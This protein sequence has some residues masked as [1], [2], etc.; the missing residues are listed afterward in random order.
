MSVSCDKLHDFV[1]GELTEEQAD[2]FRLH[3]G[4]CET[5]PARL[6][7][8]LQMVALEDAAAS[9]ADGVTDDAPTPAHEIQDVAEPVDELAARRNRRRLVFASGAVL[10]AAAAV[11][12]ILRSGSS[13]TDEGGDAIALETGPNRSL[14]LRISESDEHK[15]Y[16]VMRSG[17]RP[18][19]DISLAVLNELSE[20]GNNKRLANAYLLM[21]EPDK[22][23]KLLA[24]LE[25]TADVLA[26]R[27][28]AA[29]LL[30]DN[31]TALRYFA[32]SLAK[33][34]NNSRVLWN[35]AIVH[36]DLNLPLSAA[37]LFRR[38]A[39]LGEPG[40]AEEAAKQAA[41]LQGFREAAEQYK[42][43]YQDGNGA[44]AR[45]ELLAL[46]IVKRYPGLGRL[47]FYDAVASAGT[48][49]R[50][51]ELRPH[52]A[53]LDDSYGGASVEQFLGTVTKGIGANRVDLAAVF[54]LSLDSGV[55]D[56]KLRAAYRSAKQDRDLVLSLLVKLRKLDAQD[57]KTLLAKT[58]NYGRWWQLLA[59]TKVAQELLDEGRPREAQAM[60]E[61]EMAGCRTNPLAYRCARV[62]SLLV[63]L[64]GVMYRTEQARSAAKEALE[65][66]AQVEDVYGASRTRK[67]LAQV[68]MASDELSESSLAL[69]RAYLREELLVNPHPCQASW[70]HRIYSHLDMR[71]RNVDS[72][73]QFDELSE[74]GRVECEAPL[75]VGTAYAR[76]EI[77]SAAGDKESL[78]KFREELAKEGSSATGLRSIGLVLAEGRALISHQRDEGR[79]L[80]HDVIRRID[81]VDDRNVQEREYRA[82]AISSLAM[83]AAKASEYPEVLKYLALE[84][85]LP[86]P[87]R[88]ALGLLFEK[89]VVVVG[90]DHQGR[91]FGRLSTGRKSL[92]TPVQ[93]TEAMTFRECDEVAVIARAHL[94]REV[95]T[96]PRRHRLELS[97]KASVAPPTYQDEAIG[98]RR[99]SISRRAQAAPASAMD[100]SGT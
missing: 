16:E 87:E 94:L 27:G 72:A 85:E 49:E 61:P 6:G 8:L 83:S 78:R 95:K 81:A 90:V 4:E 7:E 76:A 82:W 30:G 52:A 10:A 89:D 73:L 38:V 56:Q 34:P 29:K 96:A 9:I 26:D 18:K 40:W 69:T 36:R 59:K 21:R 68:E 57:R 77:L 42:K 3:L 1:A 33:E 91:W 41:A 63:D 75:D 65:W 17:E 13:K 54:R 70:I 23:E 31:Q 88:C 37:E 43:A 60:I 100:G 51:E 66:A 84:L 55:A 46:D 93:P 20:S 97:D 32:D 14:E 19:A 25:Q 92:P 47:L 39:D 45:G 79:R 80:L 22:A 67:L 58:E 11:V 2:A 28:V 24:D 5:C 74:A 98:G 50:L 53:A 48:K 15:P 64:Y 62:A 12:L 35:Q 71:T 86:P 44:N 99:H